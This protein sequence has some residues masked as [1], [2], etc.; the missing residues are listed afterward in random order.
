MARHLDRGLAEGGKAKVVIGEGAFGG[1]VDAGPVV[2]PR[3]LDEEEADAALDALIDG[4]V[5][6]G[7]AESEGHVVPYAPRTIQADALVAREDD[8][9]L[10]SKRDQGRRKSAE[11]V[12]QLLD[13][14]NFMDTL[15]S[16]GVDTCGPPAFSPADRQRFANQL[17]RFIAKQPKPVRGRDSP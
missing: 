4:A 2:K 17:D 13:M 10:P 15:R 3:R 1:A 6:I 5:H 12:R 11:N 14:R 16:G 9:G 8:G 7:L